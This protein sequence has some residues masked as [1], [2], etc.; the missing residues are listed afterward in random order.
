MDWDGVNSAVND[1]EAKLPQG[2]SIV[3]IWCPDGPDSWH[4]D[5]SE[6]PVERGD[7]AY[8]VNTGEII[9]IE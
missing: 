8:R 4:G 7:A 5:R 6:C 2:V 3:R 1:A 9:A